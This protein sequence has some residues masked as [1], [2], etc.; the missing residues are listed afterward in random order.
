MKYFLFIQTQDIDMVDP[1]SQLSENTHHIYCDGNLKYSVMLT[2]V[3]IINN[4]NSFHQIQLLHGS[5]NKEW[6]EFDHLYC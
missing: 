6:Y 2:L 3:D 1:D 5:D 4:T